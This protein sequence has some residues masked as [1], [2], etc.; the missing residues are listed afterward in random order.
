[1][2]ETQHVA[3]ITVD[4]SFYLNTLTL[5]HIGGYSPTVHSD[6]TATMEVKFYKDI[7]SAEQEAAE[8][9]MLAAKWAT[10]VSP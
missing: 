7:L 5:L 1:M 8:V 4:N 2:G 3:D 9:A 10:L 6:G